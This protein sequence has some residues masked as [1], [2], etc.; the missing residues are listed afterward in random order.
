MVGYR[1][2]KYM[3]RNEKGGCFRFRV[4]LLMKFEKKKTFDEQQKIYFLGGS[5]KTDFVPI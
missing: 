5:L 1:T 3:M 2:I 4:F